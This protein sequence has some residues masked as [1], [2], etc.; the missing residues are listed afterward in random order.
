V[1]AH[2]PALHLAVELTAVSEPA[3]DPA[4]PRTHELALPE[5]WRVMGSPR[6][7]ARPLG[8]RGNPFRDL[9]RGRRA[10]SGRDR[11]PLV[12]VLTGRDRQPHETG[13]DPARPILHEDRRL[14]RIFGRDRQAGERTIRAGSI[15]YEVQ[16]LAGE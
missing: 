6:D 2:V 11:Q 7:L 1:H 12:P 16:R 13:L 15:L 4:V 5:A 8:F 10:E 14:D 9:R 3:R